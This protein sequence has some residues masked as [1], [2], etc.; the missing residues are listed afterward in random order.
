[1]DNLRELVAS[2]DTGAYHGED[3]RG[4]VER[5]GGG[6]GKTGGPSVAAEP[7]AG[8]GSAMRVDHKREEYNQRTKDFQCRTPGTEGNGLEC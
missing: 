5:V 3:N 1:M 6:A 2:E 8:Q 4:V 7:M